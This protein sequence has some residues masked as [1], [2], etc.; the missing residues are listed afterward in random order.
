MRSRSRC[1]D[2]Q[3]TRASRPRSRQKICC[4]VAEEMEAAMLRFAQA[5]DGLEREVSGLVRIA[6][7]PDVG[8]VLI[9]PLLRELFCASDPC[10]ASRD[11]AR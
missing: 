8:N 9:A 3:S 7:P 6:C 1:S 4:P 10:V 11:R 5:A 2:L